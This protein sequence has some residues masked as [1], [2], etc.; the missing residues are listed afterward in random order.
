[1]NAVANSL[2]AVG[3]GRKSSNA[4]CQK[5]GAQRISA[6]T[7]RNFSSLCPSPMPKEG[8]IHRLEEK[9]GQRRIP[10]KTIAWAFNLGVAASR[11]SRKLHG[12]VGVKDFS[13]KFKGAKFTLVV[14]MSD[15][16]VIRMGAVV[17]SN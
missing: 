14:A 11:F 2:G 6:S 17:D 16:Q 1:V 8:W 3:D 13:R 9:S 10:K 12:L 7:P 15:L 5:T 4:A